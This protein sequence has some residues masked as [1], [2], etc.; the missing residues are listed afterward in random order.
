MVEITTPLT[1]ADLRIAAHYPNNKGVLMGRWSADS[2]KPLDAP[3]QEMA[4][5]IVQWFNPQQNW[6]LVGVTVSFMSRQRMEESSMARRGPM[7]S[8]KTMIAKVKEPDKFTSSFHFQADDPPMTTLARRGRQ[9]LKGVNIPK[10]FR[11]DFKRDNVIV[12]IDP[13]GA[14]TVDVL[15]EKIGSIYP[16]KQALKELSSPYYLVGTIIQSVIDQNVRWTDQEPKEEKHPEPFSS[17]AVIVYA[18]DLGDYLAKEE[19]EVRRL[20]RQ[21]NRKFPL[22]PSISG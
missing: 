8:A 4:V 15:P 12:S 5:D 13:E 11:P 9:S 10:V 3:L 22:T 2:E 21:F 7:D 16:L 14:D 19:S 17:L 20:H 6:E 18:Q 1:L